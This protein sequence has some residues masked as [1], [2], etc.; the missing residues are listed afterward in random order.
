MKYSSRQTPNKHWL[1]RIDWVLI[2]ILTILAIFSVT[3]ISSAMGG[4]QYS[5]NFSIRQVIYYILGAFIALI[6]MLF[7]PKKLKKYIFIIFYFLCIAYRFTNFTR[8]AYYTC[9]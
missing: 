2:G 7:S 1:K 8:N 9:D 5:A 4:G 6:I 3:L